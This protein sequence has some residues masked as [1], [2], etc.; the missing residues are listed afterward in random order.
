MR[1]EKRSRRLGMKGVVLGI[2][3][4]VAAVSM[5]QLVTKV[6][7]EEP[8]QYRVDSGRIEF[9]ADSPLLR[10]LVIVAAE[11]VRGAETALREI[12]QIVARLDKPFDPT[13]HPNDWEELDSRLTRR[14]GLKLA[15]IAPSPAGTALGHSVVSSEHG[16]KLLARGSIRVSRYGLRGRGVPAEI[17]AIRPIADSD[18]QDVLFRIDGAREFLPGTT[19]EIEF[20]LVKSTQVRIPTESLLHI[21]IREFVLKQIT[22]GVFVPRPVVIVEES[23]DSVAVTGGIAPG[24][25]L[26]SRGS[27]LLKPEVVRILNSMEGSP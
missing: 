8:Q 24:D 17:I 15:S 6:N 20:Q 2:P 12:G 1:A 5:A 16:D 9:Q 13:G 10:R 21:G 19:C 4:V 26:V 3:L 27:I 23:A 25:S 14:L 7:T 22:P 18:S 11:R